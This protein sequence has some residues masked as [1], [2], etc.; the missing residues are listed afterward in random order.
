MGIPSGYSQSGK[1]ASYALSGSESRQPE[2]RFEDSE[3]AMLF[4]PSNSTSLPI[5]VMIMYGKALASSILKTN[6]YRGWCND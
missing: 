3:V 1:F 4:L 2:H 6:G 5:M